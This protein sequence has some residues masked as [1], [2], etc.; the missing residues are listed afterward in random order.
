MFELTPGVTPLKNTHRRRHHHDVDRHSNLGA[1]A[2]ALAL[3]WRSLALCEQPTAAVIM[4]RL[5]VKRTSDSYSI[6]HIRATTTALGSFYF[7]TFRFKF[8]FNI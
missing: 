4:W 7:L 6:H 3:S 8:K 2:P 5:C 1:A